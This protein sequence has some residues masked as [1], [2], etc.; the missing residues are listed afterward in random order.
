MPSGADC[1]DKPGTALAKK[2]DA[3]GCEHEGRPGM[4]FRRP[5]VTPR[6]KPRQVAVLIAGELGQVKLPVSRRV[7]GRRQG[8]T[9]AAIVLRASRRS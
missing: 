1:S 6:D 9:T 8:Y 5:H 7:I 3:L 4:A 2:L